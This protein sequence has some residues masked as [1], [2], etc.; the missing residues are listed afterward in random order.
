MSILK[1]LGAVA[2][3]FTVAATLFTG[4]A[5]AAPQEN[6]GA[7]ASSSVYWLAVVPGSLTDPNWPLD[8]SRAE[9]AT[10]TCDPVSGSHPK[11]EEACELITGSGSIVSIEEGMICPKIYFP[12]TAFSSGGEQYRETYPNRAFLNSDKGAVYQF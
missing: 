10:L 7:D 1:T 11:A 4:T 3:A 8:W 5:N 12:V 6:V 9:S 2:G